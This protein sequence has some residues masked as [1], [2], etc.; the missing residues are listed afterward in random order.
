M[1]G[2]TPSSLNKQ[3]RLTG[4][5]PA[6]SGHCINCV[7]R[8]G[9][10][11]QVWGSRE[12]DTVG[13]PTSREHFCQRQGGSHLSGPLRY[14]PAYRQ[15]SYRAPAQ[16]SPTD[17]TLLILVGRE[18]EERGQRERESER[19]ERGGRGRGEREREQPG[20]QPEMETG[21]N[22]GREAAADRAQGP[23][24]KAPQRLCQPGGEAPSGLE[25]PVPWMPVTAGRQDTAA[26][27][28]TTGSC[29][30]RCS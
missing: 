8:Q 1:W 9:P 2:I 27:M 29:R 17:A 3:R 28:S 13:R 21:R 12:Q 4:P 15:S 26:R 24:H 22:H 6:W 30:T 16:N 7:Q 11:T 20:G 14:F 19:R 23:W 25:F 18:R 5:G 10:G